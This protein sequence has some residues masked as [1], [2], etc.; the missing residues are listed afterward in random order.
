M[1]ANFIELI[2]NLLGH[3][4]KEREA[5]SVDEYAKELNQWLKKM[6]CT[7]VTGVRLESFV[8]IKIG[9][10]FGT[11]QKA[12]VGLVGQ[13]GAIIAGIHQ[14]WWNVQAAFLAGGIKNFVGTSDPIRIIKCL[15]GRPSDS[16]V[17]SQDLPSTDIDLGK[18]AIIG[19]WHG[20]LSDFYHLALVGV[21]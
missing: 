20:R 9:I 11:R 14:V 8:D 1:L 16:I 2:P 6:R 21:P 13:C 10:E 7:G 15:I 12:M 3:P 5:K 18:K 17:K 4:V 19:T